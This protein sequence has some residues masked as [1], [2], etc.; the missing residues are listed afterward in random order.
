MKTKHVIYWIVTVIIGAFMLFS[1]YSY[2]SKSP[3][4]IKG[5][6][7]ELGYPLYFIFFLGI[8]KILGVLGLLQQKWRILQEW[9]YAGFTFTF[10]GAIW[11][12]HSTGSSPLFPIIA[13]VLLII[14]YMLRK[15]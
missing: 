12:H 4:I 9:A 10:L 2:L 11:S 15:K 14:S 3:M 5:F 8:A 7:E 1:S 13:L 6:H